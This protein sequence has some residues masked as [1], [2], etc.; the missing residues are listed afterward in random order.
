MR[1]GDLL[2]AALRA[3]NLEAPAGIQ[4]W[5]AEALL[6]AAQPAGLPPPDAPPRVASYAET[7]GLGTYAPPA[8]PFPLLAGVPVLLAGPPGADWPAVARLLLLRYPGSHP[9]RLASLDTAGATLSRDE[10]PLVHVIAWHTAPAA[11]L[12]VWYLPPL[13][14]SDDLRSA[15]GLRW[16]VARLLGPGGCPWDV[17]QTPRSLRAAL[18]EEVHEVLEALDSGDMAALSEELGDLLITVFSQSEMARQAGHFALEDVFEQVSRKLIGRHPHVFGELTVEGEGQVLRNWEQIK[19]A[20]HARKGRARTSILDGVPPTLPALAM[21]QKLG[22]KAARAGFNW[23]DI[24]QVWARLQEELDE[25]AEAATAGDPSHT[26]EELG[27]TLFVLTR[28][29]D[30]LGLD[31]E[32]ALREASARFRRRFGVVEAAAARQGRSLDAMSLDELMA[33]W[34]TA[35]NA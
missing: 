5:M 20:E 30:W 21:A 13:P 14:C 22:K 24:A 31:A 4:L 18:L 11:A 29:A 1:T 15:E 16:V 17:R 28:L 32:T 19:A 12:H 23:N 8:A 7:Q 33:L 6:A 9:V 2:E 35:R 26:A 34:K 27:D 10:R 3:L 25:L